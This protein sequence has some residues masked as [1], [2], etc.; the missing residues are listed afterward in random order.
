MQNSYLFKRCDKAFIKAIVLRLKPQAYLAHEAVIQSGEAPSEIYFVRNGKV[1]VFSCNRESV[2]AILKAGD[3]FGDLEIF[4][5]GRRTANVEV[6]SM[7]QFD[8][9][10][11]AV[12]AS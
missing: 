9:A 11:K 4:T 10:S 1:K 12:V 3:I 5:G 2:Y 7:T 6:T 8:D